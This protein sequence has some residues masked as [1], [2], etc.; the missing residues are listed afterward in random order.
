M[1]LVAGDSIGIKVHNDDVT[2]TIGFVGG[3]F[4]HLEY[5]AAKFE[6]ADVLIK[7]GEQGGD[8]IMQAND[9]NDADPGDIVFLNGAGEQKARIWASPVEGAALHLSS[10]D[11]NADI[12]IKEDGDLYI[13]GT[14]NGAP[15]D[16][17]EWFE[18]EG[19]SEPGDIIGLNL[20]TGRVRKYQRGD[21]F[22]G[23]HSEDPT[24]AGNSDET[25]P[26]ILVG[27][28]GQLDFNEDQ[29]SI[30]NRVVR[31]KDGTKVGY[32]LNNGKLLLI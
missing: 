15:A 7:V 22:I 2:A 29:V 20:D 18:S 19:D 6:G 24:I 28:L 10:G 4:G 17:A 30:R 1:A 5:Y 31:T 16:Y 26:R 23:I 25:E 9:P 11:I 32:L 8:L 13:P 27:L 3:P 12:T 14:I 21:V